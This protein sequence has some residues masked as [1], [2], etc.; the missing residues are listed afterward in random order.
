MTSLRK[1]KTEY[2]SDMQDSDFSYVCLV[3]NNEAKGNDQIQ[4]HTMQDCMWS[5]SGAIVYFEFVIAEIKKLQKE[6]GIT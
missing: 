5:T 1:V 3:V 4:V 6:L 2:V